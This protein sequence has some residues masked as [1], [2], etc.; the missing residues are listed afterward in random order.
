MRLS[1]IFS[2]SLTVDGRNKCAGIDVRFVL[3][4]NSHCS[5]IYP[6][7]RAILGFKPKLLRG[8][9]HGTPELFCNRVTTI[10]GK[11]ERTALLDVPTETV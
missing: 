7:Y 9:M 11:A 2:S 10:H 6:T 3:P 5:P 8:F 1:M 4:L